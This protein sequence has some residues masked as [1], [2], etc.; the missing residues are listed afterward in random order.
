M[1]FDVQLAALPPI[2]PEKRE[3][4]SQLESF[5]GLPKSPGVCCVTEIQYPVEAVEVRGATAA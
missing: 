2:L 3:T 5:H 4:C 1:I